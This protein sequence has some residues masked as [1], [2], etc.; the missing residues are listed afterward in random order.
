MPSNDA[1]WYSAEVGLNHALIGNRR[2]VLLPE[3]THASGATFDARCRLIRFLHQRMDFDVIAIESNFLDMEGINQRL[4][5][6]HD[7]QQ[8]SPTHHG[9]HPLRT[10][11]PL[12][13]YVHITRLSGE[14]PIQV[15]GLHPFYYRDDQLI[16]KSRRFFAKA[17]LTPLCAAQWGEF[18]AILQP[19]LNDDRRTKKPQSQDLA[20]ITHIVSE[21]THA[22]ETNR[23]VLHRVHGEDRVC[24]FETV[25]IGP[26][27]VVW[28]EFCDAV[29]FIDKERPVPIQNLVNQ[30]LKRRR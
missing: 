27:A 3:A 30:D 10:Q 15:M 8:T 23:Q 7:Y 12:F 25:C 14:N 24:V 19:L 28:T 1:I 13:D 29:F 6:Q 17:E 21:L 4:S 18:E 9:L 16:E 26:K 11:R 5:D 2:F 22:I 20:K